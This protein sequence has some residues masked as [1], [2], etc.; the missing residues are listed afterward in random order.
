MWLK[1][2]RWASERYHLYRHKRS[3]S[4]IFLSAGS[5]DKIR[6]ASDAA[7]VEQTLQ[8]RWLAGSECWALQVHVPLSGSALTWLRYMSTS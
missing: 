3:F 2:E 5:L 1:T 7:S 6:I 8:G 4:S